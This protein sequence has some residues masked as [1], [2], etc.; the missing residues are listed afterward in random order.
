MRYIFKQAS[1]AILARTIPLLVAIA[2][3]GNLANAWLPTDSQ[4]VGHASAAP[5][6]LQSAAISPMS[7]PDLAPEGGNG[8]DGPDSPSASVNVGFTFQGRLLNNSLL[9]NGQYDFVFTMY[10]A[11]TGGSR[12]STPITLTNQTVSAGLFTVSL[13]FGSSAF[14]GQARWLEVEAK[15]AGGTGYTVLTPRQPITGPS[16]PSV[17][18][19]AVATLR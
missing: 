16:S 7:K 17:P 1:N 6:T 10:D 5:L 2:I 19:G 3:G 8:G 9:A 14:R 15:A 13:D 12:V 18:G 11:P 4:Q